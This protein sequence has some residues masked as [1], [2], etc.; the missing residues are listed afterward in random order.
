VRLNLSKG[1]PSLSVGPRGFT[2]NIGRRGV[3]NTVGLPG[4]GLSYTTPTTPWSDAEGR[5]PSPRRR[6][7]NPLLIAAMIAAAVLLLVWL[8]HKPG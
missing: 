1:T 2:T 8:G 6:G 7:A 4:S 3:R 5:N